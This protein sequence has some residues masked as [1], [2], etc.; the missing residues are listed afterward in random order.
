MCLKIKEYVC[1][2]ICFFVVDFKINEFFVIDIR[3]L[4]FKLLIIKYIFKN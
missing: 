3:I 1:L 4:L 2:F